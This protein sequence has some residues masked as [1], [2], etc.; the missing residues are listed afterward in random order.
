MARLADLLSAK[1]DRPVLDRT[2]VPGVFDID[3]KWGTDSDTDSGPSLFTAVQERLGLKLQASKSPVEV[4]VI[5]HIDR[6][7]RN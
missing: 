6:P 3:L 7:T 5:E 4:L 2:G 1:T